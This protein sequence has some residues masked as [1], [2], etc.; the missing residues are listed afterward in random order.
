[1]TFSDFGSI[2]SIVGVVLAIFFW[3]FPREKK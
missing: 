1:M 3:L 2:A